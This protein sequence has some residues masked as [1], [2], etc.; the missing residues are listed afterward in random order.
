VVRFLVPGT[1][2]WLVFFSSGKIW[3][4]VGMIISKKWKN[5]HVPNHQPDNIKIDFKRLHESTG[6]RL[7]RFFLHLSKCDCGS[8]CRYLA[9]GEHPSTHT[10][11][12]HIHISSLSGYMWIYIQEV[13]CRNLTLHLASYNSRLLSR[14]FTRS[15]SVVM[16]P[17]SSSAIVCLHLKH[18]S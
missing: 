14:C 5:K 6:Y 13:Q 16:T 1:N 11:T 9:P 3:K 2:N 10:H 12:L 7:S 4:S 8:Q 17:K 15:N 18:G